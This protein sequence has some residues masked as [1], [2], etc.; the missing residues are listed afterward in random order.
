[1]TIPTTPNKPPNNSME[2][3]IQKLGSPVV[4]PRTLGPIKLPSN[5]CNINIHTMNL[6]HC[7]GEIKSSI[8]ALGI[9]PR[10][11]PKN[12]MMLVIPTITLII[13][14]RSGLSLYLANIP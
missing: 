10:K 5:C 12:G 4:C 8:N 1:M 9:A 11:G 3:N 2:N 14:V 6:R 7:T 13:F